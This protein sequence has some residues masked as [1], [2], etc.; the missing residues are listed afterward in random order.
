MFK[1]LSLVICGLGIPLNAVM[2]IIPLGCRTIST[3]EK[4]CDTPFMKNK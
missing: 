1:I 4:Y 2:L 3:T